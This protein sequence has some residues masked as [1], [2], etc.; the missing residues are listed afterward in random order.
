MSR[1]ARSTLI[2]VLLVAAT[3]AIYG[4]VRQFPLV[5]FDDLSYVT[6]NPHVSSGLSLENVAWAFTHWLRRLLVATDLGV[7][8]GR[9]VAL[10]RA[11]RRAT[12]HQR[13]HFTRR[14]RACCSRSSS[15]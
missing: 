1:A 11:E 2:C 12:T 9:H 4:Q 15:G 7:V 3:W 13:R 8:P 10:R 6:D 14:A 5:D